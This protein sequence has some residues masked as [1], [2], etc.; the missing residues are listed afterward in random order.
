MSVSNNSLYIDEPIGQGETLILVHGLGGTSNSWFPQRETLKSNLRIQAYDLAGSG[1]SVVCDAITIERH[2]D[3][4]GTVAARAAPQGPIHVAGH[5]MGSIIVQHFA[6]LFPERVKSIVLAGGFL[7]PSEAAR[8]AMRMRADRARSG[9]MR[10]VADA[11]VAGGTSDDTRT[12]NLPAAAF[13]RESLLAQPAEGYA[14]NCLALADA[15]SANLTLI[16]CP[17]LLLTG[18][19]DTTAPV[20]IA[21]A[22]QSQLSQSAL[23]VIPGCGHWPT[24]ERANRVNYAMALFYARL[25][26]RL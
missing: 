26:K 2:L 10:A 4:L 15:R 1:R 9:G 19:K 22:M 13:V 18:D 25:R 20:S 6:A 24:I 12:H 16:K 3:D 8:E 17:V 23:T 11:I 7:E 14:R 5:S 21:K